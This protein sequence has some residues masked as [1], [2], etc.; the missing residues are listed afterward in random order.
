[1][2]SV[3]FAIDKDLKPRL[4]EFPWVNWSE[5]AREEF[6]KRQEREKAVERLNELMKESEITEELALKL[7]REARSRIY[8]KY[9]SKGW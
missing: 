3:T 4:D 8:N 1:M 6:L 9:K 2:A 5:L 7:G